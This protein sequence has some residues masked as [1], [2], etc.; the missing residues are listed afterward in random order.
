MKDIERFAWAIAVILALGLGIYAGHGVTAAY[1]DIELM[2]IHAQLE[3][4]QASLAEANVELE[5]WKTTMK[6]LAEGRQ[7]EGV[8]IKY[9]RPS[10]GDKP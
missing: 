9:G 6:G 2:D 5:F 7:L 1:K 3:T 4:A 10:E 8:D